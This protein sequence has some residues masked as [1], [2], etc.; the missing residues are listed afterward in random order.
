MKRVFFLASLILFLGA[1][2]SNTPSAPQASPTSTDKTPTTT[3]SSSSGTIPPPTT[4]MDAAMRVGVPFVDVG[5]LALSAQQLD[6]MDGMTFT[7]LGELK[8]VTDGQKIRGLT[9]N[10]NIKGEAASGWD[11]STYSLYAEI[12]GLPTPQ[13]ADFY[14]G[15]IVR[16]DPFAFIS[17]G[18]LVKR[19][20]VFVNG[21]TSNKNLIDF[22]LYVLTLEPDDDDPAPAAHVVE[23]KMMLIDDATKDSDND[24]SLD[25]VEPVE[26]M[27]FCTQDAK[28][29]PDGSFVGRSGPNCEFDPCPEASAASAP[30]DVTVSVT[31][32][33][34]SFE[35]S[36]I[37]VNKGDT[38]TIEFTSEQG[39]H[40][41]SLD[42]YSLRTRAVNTGESA[43]VTFVADQAGTFNYY[44]SIGS[45]RELGMEGVII[46]K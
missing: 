2:C 28:Q 22:D 43:S 20:D 14:E 31:G 24:I 26:D 19:G 10:E 3:L 27:V 11:G 40:D 1:G 44:C 36:T 13:G 25:P 46:V 12:D 16:M 17:T 8:N 35:P 15:W 45:H 21:Y 33:N 34:F 4:Q 37:T 41:F 18:K 7:H 29:C 38:V 39:F 5:K 30:K 42:E 32:K 9:F 23:G 6:E